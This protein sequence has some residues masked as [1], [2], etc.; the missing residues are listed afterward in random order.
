MPETATHCTAHLNTKIIFVILQFLHRYWSVVR[1]TNSTYVTH[2]LKHL[3]W[4]C[5]WQRH[6]MRWILHPTHLFAKEGGRILLPSTC[7]LADEQRETV[8]FADRFC[9]QPARFLCMAAVIFIP[10][11]HNWLTNQKFAKLNKTVKTMYFTYRVCK[12]RNSLS[13]GNGISRNSVQHISELRNN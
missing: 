13:L 12:T 11:Y 6:L 10:W 9:F 7:I 2:F 3:G 8:S 5:T 4:K 1:S